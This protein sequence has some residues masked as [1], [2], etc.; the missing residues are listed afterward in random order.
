MTSRVSLG[1]YQARGWKRSAPCHLP[2]SQEVP[3]LKSR[4]LDQKY[5]VRGQKPGTSPTLMF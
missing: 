3:G 5:L 1:T 4:Q 2:G